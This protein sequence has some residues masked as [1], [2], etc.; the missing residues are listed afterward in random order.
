MVQRSKRSLG[1]AKAEAMKA[2][3]RNFQHD[4][5]KWCGEIPLATSVYVA[6]SNLN[7]ALELATMQ[8]NHEIDE[9]RRGRDGHG[10][11]GIVDFD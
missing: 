10:H 7:S 6:L 11:G 4:V 5:R 3:V 9:S 1:Q 8:L 2:S